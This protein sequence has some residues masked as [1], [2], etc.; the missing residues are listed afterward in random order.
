MEPIQLTVRNCKM[1]ELSSGLRKELLGAVPG[2][3][4][5]I[6]EVRGVETT[7]NIDSALA[8]PDIPWQY[9]RV[10]LGSVGATEKATWINSAGI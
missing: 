5:G 6:D 8:A 2:A 7:A 3:S 1:V 10:L 9:R 4:S